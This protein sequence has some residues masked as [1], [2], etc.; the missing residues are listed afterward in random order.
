ML[1]YNEIGILL[2]LFAVL[3]I[4]L[5]RKKVQNPYARSIWRSA[6]LCFALYA[7]ILIIVKIRWYYVEQ[8]A[9]SFDVDQNG[10]VDLHEYTE[11]AK[12]A[13]NRVTQDTARV[14]APITVAL[15]SSAISFAFLLV[16]LFITRLKIKRTE[17]NE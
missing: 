6:L 15:L 2:G 16:D 12:E 7:I 17:V 1:S 4:L 9:M 8:H 5:V 3:I 10:F 11:E 14:Y 13:M